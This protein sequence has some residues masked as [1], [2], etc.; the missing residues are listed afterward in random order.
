MR[1][2][3]KGQQQTLLLCPPCPADGASS[4]RMTLPW[5]RKEQTKL[6]KSPWSRSKEDHYRLVSYRLIPPEVHSDPKIIQLGSESGRMQFLGLK[7]GPLL[8]LPFLST[9]PK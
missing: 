6:C 4:P 7:V 1:V 3:L 8:S 9:I 5:S 2:C